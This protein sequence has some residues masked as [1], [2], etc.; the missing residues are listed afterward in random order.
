MLTIRE[1]VRAARDVELVKLHCDL[2]RAQMISEADFRHLYVHHPKLLKL[3]LATA[4][5]WEGGK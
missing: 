4:R 3:S 2:Q 1:K 5:L